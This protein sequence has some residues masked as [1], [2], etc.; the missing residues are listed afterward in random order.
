MFKFS[1]LVLKCSQQSKFSLIMSKRRSSR[2][3]KKEVEES[4]EIETKQAKEL[5]DP[6]VEEV[7]FNLHSLV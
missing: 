3:V 5:V 6:V 1:F 2:L 4:P 7:R